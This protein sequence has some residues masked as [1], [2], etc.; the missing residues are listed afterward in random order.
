[1][2]GGT[3]K[4][5]LLNKFTTKSFKFCFQGLHDIYDNVYDNVR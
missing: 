1:M 4:T 2:S 3:N 5:Y